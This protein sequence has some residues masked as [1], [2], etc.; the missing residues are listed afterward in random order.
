MTCDYLILKI[1]TKIKL[2]N[3][4][5]SLKPFF[6]QHTKLEQRDMM[7]KALDNH[8]LVPAMQASKQYSKELIKRRGLIQ[9]LNLQQQINYLCLL[10]DLDPIP[11]QSYAQQSLTPHHDDLSGSIS[12]QSKVAEETEQIQPP[13]PEYLTSN[14]ED[15]NHDPET[16]QPQ[17]FS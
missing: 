11:F 4:S 5:C 6:N 17:E 16:V 1:E 8:W 13:S 12:K 9:I 14:L 2:D 7:L 15:N 10:L 3:C